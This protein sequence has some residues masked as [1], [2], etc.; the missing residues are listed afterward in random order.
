MARVRYLKVLYI[1]RVLKRVRT[2]FDRSAER[3]PLKFS[4]MSGNENATQSQV[5]WNESCQLDI[6]NL[7]VYISISICLTTV[8]GMLSAFL[9]IASASGVIWDQNPKSRRHVSPLL[10]ACL[11]MGLLEI[12]LLIFGSNNLYNAFYK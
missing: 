11:L 12:I 1:I 3:V 8:A 7:Q 10:H 2:P 6:Y 5:I 4:V 9:A